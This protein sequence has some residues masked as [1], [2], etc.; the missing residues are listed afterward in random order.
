MARITQL[1]KRALNYINTHKLQT[2]S[3]GVLFLVI[4]SYAIAF[5]LPQQLQFSYSDPS[6]R[7]RVVVA[8]DLHKTVDA[9]AFKVVFK[10]ELKVGSL[11]VASLKVCVEPTTTPRTDKTIVATA[12]FGGLFA[13]SHIAV[14]VPRAPVANTKV[15]N[16]PI[17]VASSLRIDLSSTDKLFD[18]KLKIANNQASCKPHKQAINCDI[19]SLEL[20]QGKQYD[21]ELTRQFGN[22]RPQKLVKQLITTLRA[23]TV[24]GSSIK[25]QQTIYNNPKTLTFTT[26]K[27]LLAASAELKNKDPKQKATTIKTDVSGKTITITLTK[28]LDRESSYELALTNVKA[29]DGSTLA[30]PYKLSFSVSGG[31][32]VQTINIGSSRVAQSALVTL[33]FDQPLSD[34]QLVQNFIRLIGGS[35]TA[36]KTSPTQV[37]LGLPALPRCTTFAIQALPGIESKHG[38]KN[39]TLWKYNSRTICHTVSTIGTSVQGRAINSYTFGSSGPVTLF[40]GALHGDEVSSSLLLQDWINELEANHGR[41]PANSRVVVVP[42]VNP[43]GIARGT[44]NN[45]RNVNLNRNFPTNNWVKNINDTNGPVAGGGGS[46]PLSEPEAKALAN[47]SL[48]LR[49]RLMLSYHA[50]GSLVIG[51]P[52]GYSAGYAA[53]YAS[54]VGYRNATG[55]SSSTFDYNITGSYEDWTIQKVGIPSMVIELGSYSYRNFAHHR[56]AFWSMLR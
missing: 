42:S 36:T 14:E 17:P 33:T 7:W 1:V 31:P 49:P 44:R 8:P 43:D 37:T 32:K 54:M 6:C 35:A 21:M 40:V 15:F 27:E 41:K 25:N 23:T 16:K 45:A 26:D 34:T 29:T 13:R 12:P 52:G 2:I 9:K 53:R 5:F 10:D 55:Q 30:A 20:K 48:S 39:K 56:E 38:I 46:A 11:A 22:D 3:A 47:L 18:Y 50:I 51:D 19:P 28:P 4:F 24:T